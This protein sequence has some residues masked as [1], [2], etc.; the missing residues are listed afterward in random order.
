MGVKFNYQARTPTGESQSGV[1]EASSKEAALSL[2]QSYGLY[3]TSLKEEKKVQAFAQKLEIFHRVSRKDI[4]SFSRQLAILFKSNVP[5]VESLQTIANQTKKQNFK[6]KIIAIAEKV[7]GGTPLSQALGIYPKL[8]SPFFVSVVKSGEATGKLS[9]VL[10]YLADHTE[11]EYNF[12]SQL[13]TA[14][15]YPIFILAVFMIILILM[16]IL[17]V[18]KL[19]EVLLEA[20]GE[21]PFSTKMVISISDALKNWWWL[22]LVAFFGFFIFI[23]QL[24]KTKQ[25]KIFIDRI[26]LNLP[27]IGEF[28]KKV[29][30][31]RIAENLSTLISAGF[32]IIQA[33]ETTGEIVG[34]SVYSGIILKTGEGVKKGEPI[35][36]FLSRYPDLF[37]SM[38]IQMMVVGEKT[39]QIDLTLMNIVSY[40][41]KETERALESFVKLLEPIMIVF[42][43]LIVA[44]FMSSILLPL[45]RIT[46]E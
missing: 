46:F 16:S 11:K 23:S 1:V 26:S 13:V 34:N 22:I 44:G 39:G 31:A 21:L 32:P 30:L 15:V 6:E 17:V 18:P 3:I 38:F 8:F 12:Y 9:E 37:P 45:Y 42:L 2:L 19:T 25:G 10:G 24:I 29:Y 28:F 27:I 40:Y 4:V 33:L 35:S 7:E 41:Q 43:G 36:L 5:V 14:M 20:G